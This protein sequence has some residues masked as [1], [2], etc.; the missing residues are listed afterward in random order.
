MTSWGAVV[1]T[2]GAKFYRHAIEADLGI[3]G[4][5]EAVLPIA[6]FEFGASGPEDLTVLLTHW[7]AAAAAGKL[8]NVGDIFTHLL[9]GTPQAKLFMALHDAQARE[10]ALA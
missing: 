9:S 3:K 7:Q 10:L 6:R 4:T 5:Y 1:S 8:E 2:K